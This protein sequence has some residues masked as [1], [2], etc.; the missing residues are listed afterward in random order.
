MVQKWTLIEVEVIRATQKTL[1]HCGLW[2]FIS[3]THK[4]I[5]LM[6]DGVVGQH[7]ESLAPRSVYR[8]I[9]R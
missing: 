8:L 6:Y 4:P 5:L 2:S 1:I 9:L 3:L 7:L